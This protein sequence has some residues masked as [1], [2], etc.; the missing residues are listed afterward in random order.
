MKDFSYKYKIYDKT[1]STTLKWKVKSDFD[2]S[3]VRSNIEYVR[4]SMGAKNVILLNQ[5]HGVDVLDA[6]N[7]NLNYTESADGVVTSKANIAL[8]IQTADCV[9][10]LF[11][12]KN[13]VGA[14]HCGWRGAKDGIIRNIKDI[15]LQKLSDIEDPLERDIFAIIGPSIHQSSYEVGQEYYQSFL[16][17][18]QANEIFFI[19]SQRD[20]HY[21]FDLP[22]FIAEC[23]R[24]CD[25]K[26]HTHVQ[27]DTYSMPKK[28]PSYRRYCHEAVHNKDATRGGNILSVIM[29]TM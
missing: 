26:M 10:V 25:I 7:N 9:P 16:D 15:M 2:V 6:D 5:V 3:E 1:S 4:Q 28:Y 13:S 27:E 24:K 19:N 8:A 22:A 20:G 12:S 17:D 18:N 14:A 11:F 21:L 23:L 29:L